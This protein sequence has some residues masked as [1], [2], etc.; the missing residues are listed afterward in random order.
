M[1]FFTAIS[2]SFVL[3]FFCLLSRG[4]KTVNNSVELQNTVFTFNKD[5]TDKYFVHTF[6]P[7]K[8]RITVYSNTGKKLTMKKGDAYGVQRIVQGNYGGY[9]GL[10]LEF[11]DLRGQ[12]HSLNSYYYARLDELKDLWPE[13]ADAI[14]KRKEEAGIRRNHETI[15]TLKSIGLFVLAVAA[16]VGLMFLFFP[17]GVPGS[18]SAGSSNNATFIGDG[19]V[20]SGKS[21]GAGGYTESGTG[22]TYERKDGR[23]TRKRMI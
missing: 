10:W 18:G 17:K 16:G 23:Y 4:Q 20:R 8:D 14:D 3:V 5:A 13:Y 2:I 15:E 7:I 22:H 11:Y 12:H 6:T 9:N 21:N 19:N 1:K